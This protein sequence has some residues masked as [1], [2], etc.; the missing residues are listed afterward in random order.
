MEELDRLGWEAGIAFR[1][2]GTRVGIRV[3]RANILERLEPLFPPG[4][5]PAKS[6]VVDRL[7]SLRVGPNQGTGSSSR[8]RWYNLLYAN[9]QR[10]SR[11][12]DL[13]DLLQ[14]LVSD[15][16][17]FVAETSET[18][19]FIHAGVV[20]WRGRAIVLPGKTFSG[21]STLV[22]GLVRAGATY[23]SDEYAVFDSR[24]RVHP[25]PRPHETFEEDRRSISELVEEL[26]VTPGGPPL[27]V[28]LVI[29]SEYK[30]GASWS[31]QT[32]SPGQAALALLA[33]TASARLEPQRALETL[34]RAVGR[35]P[36]LIGARGEVDEVLEKMLAELDNA[37]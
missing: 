30:P 26:G 14:V 36:V 9:T 24:G 35:A 6:R 7:Y 31:P 16:R 5:K 28:G 15:M 34:K 8:V 22:A 21:K 32:L 1:V 10:I 17:L 29:L 11:T 13:D 23:Y 20:G 12:M 33:N 4:W 27:P 2:Y 25:F 18:R 37:A 19:V 3:N